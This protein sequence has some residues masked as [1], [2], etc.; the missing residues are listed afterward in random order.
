MTATVAG[1]HLGIDTHANRPAAG[2]PPVGSLYSCS[3][4]SLVYR[5]DGSSWSTWA[6]LGGSA[7]TDATISVSDVTTNNVSTSAHGW[8]PKGDGSTTKFL[9]AN[10]AYSTP[11]GGGGVSVPV[12]LHRAQGSGTTLAVTAPAN[13]S[14]LIL[15]VMSANQVTAV[16]L[17][18][19]TWTKMG[20]VTTTF[21]SQR[22]AIWAGV[23][24]A[25]AGTSISITTSGGS[26]AT[27][28]VEVADALTPTAGTTANATTS[29]TAG[30]A[31]NPTNVTASTFVACTV[32]TDNFGVAVQADLNVPYSGN[33]S[34]T[35]SALL[36]G[37]APTGGDVIGTLL[38][39]SGSSGAAL[40][41]A[42]T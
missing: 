18:N 42:I 17:T 20:E 34:G 19:V 4:H 16:A 10:G 38:P 39:G 27:T 21:S 29:G 22:L 8:A 28:C 33:K 32:G 5:T 36:V 14:R 40:I 30:A 11:A 13:G 2:T 23:A 37:Y 3:T 12:V 25:S 41:C 6:T 9:N 35:A 7:V 24:A 15:G 31:T 26:I 1:I